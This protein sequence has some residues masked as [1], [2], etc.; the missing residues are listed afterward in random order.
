MMAQVMVPN[1]AASFAMISGASMGRAST[2]FNTMRQIGSAT[3]VAVLS[4]VLIGVGSAQAS[5]GSVS[6]DISAYH[7]AFV[8]AACFVFGAV[9]LLA[10]HSRQ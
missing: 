2:F 8:T 5:G 3:G 9:P 10:Q 1:Q 4:T 6:P 7:W